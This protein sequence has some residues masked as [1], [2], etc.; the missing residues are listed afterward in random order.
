MESSVTAIT[1]DAAHSTTFVIV[2]NARCVD[3]SLTSK[4]HRFLLFFKGY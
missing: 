2:V 1:Q 4:S 3:A